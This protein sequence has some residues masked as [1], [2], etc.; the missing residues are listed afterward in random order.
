GGCGAASCPKSPPPRLSWPSKPPL[1]GAGRGG[2]GPEFAPNGPSVIQGQRVKMRLS[3]GSFM[4]GL[5]VGFGLACDRNRAPCRNSR[6]SVFI[7]RLHIVV[8]YKTSAKTDSHIPWC[9]S[10]AHSA[11]W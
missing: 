8:N 7:L 6:Q 10:R 4:S 1:G 9:C 5:P 3:R 11:G 2:G